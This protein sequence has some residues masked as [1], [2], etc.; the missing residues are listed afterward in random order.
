MTA[1]IAASLPYFHLGAIDTGIIP[2]QSFGILVALGVLIGAALLRR[3]AEWHGVSDDHIRGL[4]TWV[5]VAGFLGAHWFDVIAY[6]WDKLDEPW[7][8]WPAHEIIQPPSQAG[9]AQIH[10]GFLWLP[11]RLWDGIS[12]YGGFIGGSIGFAIYVWWKRLPVRLFADVTIAGLLPAFSIGRMGCSVVSDHI[13]AMVSPDAWYSFLAMD[14]PAYGCKAGAIADCCR[15]AGPGCPDAVLG[16]IQELAQSPNAQIVNDHLLAWNLGLTELLY[17]I[18]VNIVILYLAFRPSKRMNAG[19]ITALTGLLYAPV[20]FFL[21]YLRPEDTDPRHY[22]LTFAQWASILA[23]AVA[24]YVLWR[25]SKNGKPAD[26]VAA[27]SGEAQARLKL[28]LKEAEDEVDADGGGDDAPAKDKKTKAKD[29]P[30][31]VED[32]EGIS[33]IDGTANV[34]YMV[35]RDVVEAVKQALDGDEHVRAAY[36]VP[37]RVH[38]EQELVIGLDLDDTGDAAHWKV[39]AGKL[40]KWPV[41]LLDNKQLIDIARGFDRKIFP[42]ESEAGKKAAG[43][44]KPN[45]RAFKE[46]ILTTP[47]RP[48][49]ETPL[50]IIWPDEDED[51][52]EDEGDDEEAGDDEKAAEQAKVTDAKDK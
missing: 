14:Y 30:P 49:R 4:L 19:Y 34:A 44:D 41:L 45:A 52:D 35:P 20:R 39:L 29:E 31:S 25:I 46:G 27:T 17:L 38:G 7:H 11:L 37:L 13:G 48:K 5:M 26:V 1:S 32:D 50:E 22:G 42:E 28:I 18:P 51:E 2:I 3:Y 23:V 12:S 33:L 24:G 16:P 43:I 15:Q 36:Y 6:Q 9:G 21:D 40:A 10:D 47:V 8:W